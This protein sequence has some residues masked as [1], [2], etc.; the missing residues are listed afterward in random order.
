MP[1][2]SVTNI[3]QAQVVLKDPH[4]YTEFVME[5]N[6]GDT[7]TAEVSNDLLQRLAPQLTA[8]ETPSYDVDGTTIIS[9]IKWSASHG[10]YRRSS[11]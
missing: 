4:G 11:P 9:G 1:Q 6:G 10:Q 2:I 5:V 3:G 8:A 7:E